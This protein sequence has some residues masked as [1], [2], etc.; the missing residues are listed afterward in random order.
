MSDEKLEKLTL[1]LERIAIAIETLADSG[2]V[3][4]A[5]PVKL[6]STPFPWA[7]VSTRC[8]DQLRRE[9]EKEWET[10]FG[11]RK[12]PLSCEDLVSLGFTYLT[13]NAAIRNW[14][15]VSGLEIAKVLDEL[16]FQDWV[17]T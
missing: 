3:N 16:G 6:P 10:K 17:R 5:H 9:V 8:R 7:S 1:L 14:G 4:A 2:P 15:K 11:G 12:W 13:R